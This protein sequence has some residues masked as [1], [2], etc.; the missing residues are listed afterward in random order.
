MLG[1]VR[2]AEEHILPPEAVT[3]RQEIGRCRW[4]RMLRLPGVDLIWKDQ[5]SPNDFK[6]PIQFFFFQSKL[7]AKQPPS[8]V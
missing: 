7:F 3:E 5:N 4:Q 1:V 2:G 6:D 8:L